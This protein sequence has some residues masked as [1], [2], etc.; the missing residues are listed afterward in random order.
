MVGVVLVGHLGML[1]PLGPVAVVVP[2]FGSPFAVG[3][4]TAVLPAESFAASFA[5]LGSVNALEA[6]RS[7]SVEVVVEIGFGSLFLSGSESMCLLPAFPCRVI[8]VVL[9]PLQKMVVGFS[10]SAVIFLCGC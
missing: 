7:G 4:V 1:T 2:F 8:R 3:E 9:V 5:R 6:V 10:H